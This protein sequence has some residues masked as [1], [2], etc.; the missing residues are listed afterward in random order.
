MW[1]QARCEGRPSP[2]K[3][4]T[5]SVAYFLFF[6]VRRLCFNF[7]IV[8]FGN[9]FSFNFLLRSLILSEESSSSVTI[10]L[11]TFSSMG[12]S[13]IASLSSTLVTVDCCCCCNFSLG[14]TCSSKRSNESK[15]WLNASKGLNRPKSE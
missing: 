9:P 8:S 14:K 3:I 1:F 12:S 6:K 11:Q 7:S 5:Y 13:S 10:A 4:K 15:S 2:V